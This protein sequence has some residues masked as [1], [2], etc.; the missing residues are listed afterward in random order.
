VEFAFTDPRRLGRVR[1]AASVAEI[2]KGLG[3]DALRE[4]PPPRDFVALLSSRSC[5]IKALLLDQS[6]LAGIGNYLADEVLYAAGVHPESSS[7]AV[8]G[9]P[10][11]VADLRGAIESVVSTACAC[12][13]DYTR[14]PTSWLF[15]VRWGKGK[16]GTTMPNGD[17]V[18]WITVGGRTS[19]VVLAK[20][21][22]P[23]KHSSPGGAKVGGGV[24]GG[25]GKKSCGGKKRARVLLENN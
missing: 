4:L 13:A 1:R 8:G 21:G 22:R 16:D 5:P 14:F 6:V 3:P 10:V 20:Q 18:T 24:D 7:D 25:G 23:V 9:D 12:S 2:V 11:Q 19:A 15:H 17:K